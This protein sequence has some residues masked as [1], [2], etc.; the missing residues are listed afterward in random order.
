MAVVSIQVANP[1]ET[2]VT[3]NAKT[4]VANKVTTLSLDDATTEAYQFL[5]QGCALASKAA[6]LTVEQ[7][8]EGSY[9]LY[10]E[11]QYA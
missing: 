9:L 10:S 5:A 4:A 2:N 8:E 1:K 3:V 7:R 11:S 6:G